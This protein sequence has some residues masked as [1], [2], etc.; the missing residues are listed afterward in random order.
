M[1][2]AHPPITGHRQEY[3]G[4]RGI[5]GAPDGVAGGVSE[6]AADGKAVSPRA[7]WNAPGSAPMR[8]PRTLRIA[9]LIGGFA[10]R[11]PCFPRRETAR[12]GAHGQ[13]AWP[14]GEN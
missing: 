5:A 3:N 13:G 14:K 9:A 7:V 11:L 4:R 10:H 2:N 6:F 1:K 8:L 12:A